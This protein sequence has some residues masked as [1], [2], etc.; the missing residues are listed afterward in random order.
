MAV[1]SMSQRHGTNRLLI[2]EVPSLAPWHLPWPLKVVFKTQTHYIKRCFLVVGEVTEDVGRMFLRQPLLD[3]S[4]CR[5]KWT[6]NYFSTS[7]ARIAR[8]MILYSDSIRST[9]TGSP[10]SRCL[11]T[12]CYE[13]RSAIATAP[14]RTAVHEAPATMDSKGDRHASPLVR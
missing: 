5:R 3:A 7:K 10:P 11:Q 1:P 4:C 14:N 13:I 9:L 2:D 6:K 8:T 12:A